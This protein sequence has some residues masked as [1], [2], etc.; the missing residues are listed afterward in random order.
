MIP[1]PN[2]TPSE[3]SAWATVA[4]GASSVVALCIAV[5]VPLWQ[6]RAAEP[7]GRARDRREARRLLSIAAELV[8]KSHELVKQIRRLRGLEPGTETHTQ[9]GEQER[10]VAQLVAALQ[11]LPMD[12]L[13][14][15][16]AAL[17]LVQAIATLDE[18]VP[19]I[20]WHPKSLSDKA[21]SGED[22]RRPWD[23]IVNSLAAASESLVA[24]L[25]ALS[26]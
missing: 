26:A 2:L 8:G 5:G 10:A 11:H 14:S 3:W 16:Q 23:S 9:R 21:P 22:Y 24:E 7:N 15:A 17:N 19:L 25:A 4:Q 13:P 1:L 18:C 12:R 20:P 6:H